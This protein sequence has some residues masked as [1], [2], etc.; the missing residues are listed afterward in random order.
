MKVKLELIVILKCNDCSFMSSFVYQS[1]IN[2]T[3]MKTIKMLLLV[4]AITFSS[5]LSASTAPRNA[6][7]LAITSDVLKRLK[8]PQFILEQD[9]KANVTLTVNKNNEIVVLSVD[10]DNEEIVNYIKSRLNY[11]KI[12]VELYDKSKTYIVPVTLKI[13]E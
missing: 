8:N 11:S 12:S 3:I 2:R 7:T 9:T 13:E 1:L 5:V 6:E 4:V 10:S